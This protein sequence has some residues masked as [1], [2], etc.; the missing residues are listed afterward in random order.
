MPF[1]DLEVVMKGLLDDGKYADMKISCQEHDFKCHRA[2]MCSQSPYFDVAL[3]NGF[4]VSET[5][6]LLL[7]VM[8]V[9]LTDMTGNKVISSQ[10]TR[11]GC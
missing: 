7:L 5:L 10:P 2:V 4:K 9:L 3:N 1:T 11:R 8:I 6:N